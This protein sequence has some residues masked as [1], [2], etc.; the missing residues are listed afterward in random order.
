MPEIT[1]AQLRKMNILQSAEKFQ[2]DLEQTSP[3][4][5]WSAFIF[6]QS[7]Q[8]HDYWVAPGA[9]RPFCLGRASPELEM[10]RTGD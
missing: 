6:S 2:A 7:P 5:L 3:E 10:P 9:V 8:G 1:E 4:W